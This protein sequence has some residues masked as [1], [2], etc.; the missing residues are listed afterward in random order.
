MNKEW[1][2][3]RLYKGYDDPKFAADEAKLDS[4]IREITEFSADLSGG[5]DGCCG[6]SDVLLKSADVGEH[7]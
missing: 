4:L 3:E 5:T 2:L 6:G 7:F 1:S